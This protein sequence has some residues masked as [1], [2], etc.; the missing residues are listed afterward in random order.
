[1]NRSGYDVATLGADAPTFVM[2]S[3]PSRKTTVSAAAARGTD[4]FTTEGTGTDA[5]TAPKKLPAQRLENLLPKLFLG[6]NRKVLSRKIE[7]ICVRGLMEECSSV[8]AASTSGQAQ[9]KGSAAPNAEEFV[10]EVLVPIE[11]WVEAPNGEIYGIERYVL[12]PI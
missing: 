11:D 9:P 6:K 1:M 4:S 2:R 10:D 5:K 7:E 8:A 3:S 12:G